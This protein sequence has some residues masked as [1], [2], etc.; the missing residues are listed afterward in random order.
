M[1]YIEIGIWVILFI[2]IAIGKL[3]EKETIEYFGFCCG[4]YS[5]WWIYNS[6]DSIDH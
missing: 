6:R 1:T 4:L 5:S 3:N 2:G